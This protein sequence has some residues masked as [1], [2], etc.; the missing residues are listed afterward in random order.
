M[1][2]KSILF[3]MILSLV[4]A[5]GVTALAKD[6]V[7][8][9]QWLAVPLRIDGLDQDWQDATFLTDEA[10]KARYSV[11]ND[12][13][14][15]YVMFIFPD[16]MSSTTLEYTGM[17][18]YFGVDGKK[19]KNLGVLFTKRPMETEL[20]IAELEKRGQPLTEEQKAELRKQK[21]H[22]VFVEESINEKKVAAP[23]DPAVKTEP[24]VYRS[25]AKQR[26]LY[27]EF[28][29]PLSRVN[30]PRGIGAE[31]GK[32]LKI[33]FEWGGMTNEIMK[34]IMADRA[35]S[36]ATARQGASGMSS[37]VAAGGGGEGEGDGGD[38]AAFSRDP[39][40]KKH[41]FWI[42]LKLAAQ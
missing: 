32:S 28:R 35:A 36:G 21:S 22:V 24:P 25:A 40:F 38:F 39:R 17:K 30:E 26:V 9:S 34:N 18:V 6:A 19:S 14:D 15:L 23:A 29:I 13:K 1:T 2:K 41:S 16:V 4:A 5:L 31:P 10:S 27:C 33:G 11:K 42:D 7:V 8:E 20:I 37:S 3:P 12:G